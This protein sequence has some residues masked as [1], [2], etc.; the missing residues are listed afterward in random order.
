[1]HVKGVPPPHC[2]YLASDG[3]CLAAARI[4][5][6]CRDGSTRCFVVDERCRARI[7][8]VVGDGVV[9]VPEWETCQ[10]YMRVRGVAN[11]GNKS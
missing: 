10:F 5:L 6:W 7:R 11:Q 1:M 8:V 2:P 4:G 3:Q 9:E